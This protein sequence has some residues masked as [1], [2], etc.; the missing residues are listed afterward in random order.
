MAVVAFFS[1]VL[2][3]DSGFSI[4]MTGLGFALLLVD[5]VVSRRARR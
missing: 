3:H 4:A 2:S 1:A 5:D